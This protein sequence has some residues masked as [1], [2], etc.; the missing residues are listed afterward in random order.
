MFINHS[1]IKLEIIT[2]SLENLPIFEKYIKGEIII[3][4]NR[5]RTK[6]E[7]IYQYREQKKGI[8]LQI[9]QPLKR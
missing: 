6:V 3:E 8:S 2:F 4:T 1:G 9:L 7:L 5:L